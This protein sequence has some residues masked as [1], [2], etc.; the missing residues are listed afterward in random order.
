MIYII[1]ITIFVIL[2]KESNSIQFKQTSKSFQTSEGCRTI[3]SLQ[4]NIK[5]NPVTVYDKLCE[6]KT[7]NQWLSPS[8]KFKSVGIQKFDKVDQYCEEV[9]GLFESSKIKWQVR[10]IKKPSLLKVSSESSEGTIAWNQLELEFI[11]SPSEV[12][13]E[14]KLIWMYSWTVTNPLVRF[15]EEKFVRQSMI[16]DNKIALEKFILSCSE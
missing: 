3:T 13:S 5:S 2:L 10:D 8:S 1:F 15:I 6:F 7:W 4:T 11:L 12:P 16:N 9:F 14:T